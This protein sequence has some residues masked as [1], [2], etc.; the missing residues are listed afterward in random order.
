MDEI[1]RRPAGGADNHDP[2]RP[3]P[4][5]MSAGEQRPLLHGQGPQQRRSIN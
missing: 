1:K 2:G 3:G 5:G 4:D